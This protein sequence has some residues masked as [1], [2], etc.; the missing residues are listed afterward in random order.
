MRV[1]FQN[2]NR[3]KLDYMVTQ[4]NNMKTVIRIG[5]FYVGHSF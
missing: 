5:Q 2:N 1:I 4:L 3:R